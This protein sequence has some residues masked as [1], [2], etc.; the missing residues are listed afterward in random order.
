VAMIAHFCSDRE[1]YLYRNESGHKSVAIRMLF[2]CSNSY[3]QFGWG[4]LLNLES[5]MGT[6][7]ETSQDIGN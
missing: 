3:T 5:I 1:S 7:D 6:V 4:I 2:C